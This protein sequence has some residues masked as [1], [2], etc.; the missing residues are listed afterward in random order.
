MLQDAGDGD[1]GGVG[2]ACT[3]NGQASRGAVNPRTSGR[4]LRKADVSAMR[5]VSLTPVVAL[6]VQ[7]F[8]D[9]G[10]RRLVRI[11]R[12]KVDARSWSTTANER[13]EH[14]PGM[15]G[16]TVRDRDTC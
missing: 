12:C 5:A 10:D 2:T 9:S 3:E 6:L 4:H 11:D 15:A 16:E 1:E 7:T 14:V 8:L 13:A